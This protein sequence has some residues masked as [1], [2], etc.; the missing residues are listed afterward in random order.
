MAVADEKG[1][2]CRCKKGLLSYFDKDV[3]LFQQT[4]QALGLPAQLPLSLPPE[5]TQLPVSGRQLLAELL[6]LARPLANHLGE[7][8]GAVL[9]TG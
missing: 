8:I 9:G 2:C 5:L 1:G 4:L 3:F 7:P 6:Q